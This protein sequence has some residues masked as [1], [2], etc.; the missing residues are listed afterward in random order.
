MSG[1]PADAGDGVRPGARII[2]RALR[3][4][5]A[6]LALPTALAAC[7]VILIVLGGQRLSPPAPDW[8]GLVAAATVLGLNA[9]GY[10]L[11]RAGRPILASPLVV[12]S[13]LV[14]ALIMLINGALHQTLWN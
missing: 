9:W 3:V 4:L 7:A 2:G 14:F 6:L 5:H 1:R 12:G 8:P 13:W 11:A 10:R